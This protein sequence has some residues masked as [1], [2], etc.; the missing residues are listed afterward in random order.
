MYFAEA[1]HDQ[2]RL[3]H[4]IVGNPFQPVTLDPAWL[5]PTVVSLAQE[6][7]ED[8]AYDRLPLLTDVLEIAGCDNAEVLAHCRGP[9]PHVRG[10]WVVDRRLSRSWPENQGGG[11]SGG[12]RE[13]EPEI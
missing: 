3:L 4:D 5:T 6:I 1:E 7:Y 10:C 2:A 8:C 11:E 9:G 13:W 12:R